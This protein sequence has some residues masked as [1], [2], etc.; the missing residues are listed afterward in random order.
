MAVDVAA[1][2]NSRVARAPGLGRLALLLFALAL[3]AGA[4][5]ALADVYRRA[6]SDPK[7]GQD[8]RNV[9]AAVEAYR[10]GLDPYYVKNLKADGWLSFTYPPAFLDALSP[11]CSPALHIARDRVWLYPLIGLAAA[12]LVAGRRRLAAP[13]WR[14]AAA[15][16]LVLAGLS[17]FPWTYQTGNIQWLSGLLLAGFLASLRWADDD[18]ASQ[19]LQLKW[20]F[21]AAVLG[22]YAS[23]KFIELP[24][25]L[26]L[27]WLPANFRERLKLLA[28]AGAVFAAIFAIGYFAYGDLFSTFVASLQGRIP[29]QHSPA[30]EGCNVSLY[31]FSKP[32]AALATNDAVGRGLTSLAIYAGLLALLAWPFLKRLGTRRSA[33]AVKIALLLWYLVQP[34]LKQYTLFDPAVILAALVF[35]LPVLAVAILGVVDVLAPVALQLSGVGGLIAAWCQAGEL[36]VSY[37]VVVAAAGPAAL[38]ATPAAAPS[39]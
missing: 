17:G 37:F 5:L 25:L 23:L 34:R 32:F 16:A 13:P 2:E 20:Y 30:T 29:D 15:V 4:A 1:H 28:F 18:G 24:A 33:L 10:A 12:V 31:C 39:P 21:A 35:E 9:C 22:L 14:R 38:S 7:A 36:L 19:R 6:A 11:V 8:A 3:L 27:L 26:C